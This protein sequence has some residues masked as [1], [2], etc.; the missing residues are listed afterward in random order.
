MPSGANTFIPLMG[1]KM[2]PY[3][4]YLPTAGAVSLEAVLGMLS[5]GGL[6]T[7]YNPALIAKNMMVSE[8][9]RR[10][11]SGAPSPA[12]I[13]TTAQL[14]TG[15]Q[16]AVGG[17]M[18]PEDLAA[19]A[20][21]LKGG[22][23][24]TNL[25]YSMPGQI[26]FQL[27]KNVP[28]LGTVLSEILPGLTMRMA[29]APYAMQM[30]EFGRMPMAQVGARVMAMADQ[31]S[32]AYAAQPRQFGNL[33]ADQ[34]GQL[35]SEAMQ[36]SMISTT[37]AGRVMPALARA[38]STLNMGFGP[39]LGMSEALSTLQAFTGG[40]AMPG[41][42]MQNLA[43][44][45]ASTS[46]QT[47]RTVQDL[48][49][50]GEQW[51]A[52]AGQSGVSPAMGAVTGLA[53]YSEIDATIKGS[54]A[55]GGRFGRMDAAQAQRI[56]GPK[57]QAAWRSPHMMRAVG[58]LKGVRMAAAQAGI[59]TRDA[60]G[61]LRDINLVAAE[62]GADASRITG[63][64]TGD[65]SG[66]YEAISAPGGIGMGGLMSS[67]RK[68]GLSSTSAGMMLT[69]VTDDDEE[70]TTTG[71]AGKITGMQR[72]ER[73]NWITRMFGRR[74][75]RDPAIARAALSAMI[76]APDTT[77]MEQL[78]GQI[79]SIS[80]ADRRQVGTV[81]AMLSALYPKKFGISLRDEQLWNNQRAYG[82]TRKEQANTVIDTAV[83][84]GA[85]GSVVADI[86]RDLV[87]ATESPDGTFGSAVARATGLDAPAKIAAAADKAM[88]TVVQKAAAY[89]VSTVE[90][91]GGWKFAP[92]KDIPKEQTG[93]LTSYGIEMRSV[94]TV[95]TNTGNKTASARTVNS[96]LN[97]APAEGYKII[98][99]AGDTEW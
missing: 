88:S 34:L 62:L 71:M 37:N 29:A 40:A 47:G 1:S 69:Q 10:A 19:L 33:S 92:G 38:V 84:S 31:I 3:G 96:V 87:T 41:A 82:Q 48:Q 99:G 63:M 83:A 4:H 64:I 98:S 7:S 18:K 51:G 55:L 91:K 85:G 79:S 61:N 58:Y 32:S 65:P 67:L 13:Q 22:T 72:T 14:V 89:G 43:R 77:S 54:A 28:I 27:A 53:L 9:Y 52:A 20:E 50:Y 68:L 56:F 81:H 66:G 49:V 73:L 97:T 70:M 5:Q 44:Q 57:A 80:G 2:T 42:Y 93:V 39:Q 78:Y 60:N 75:S 21:R 76:S 16:Q 24:L 30:P 26:G 35:M 6:I 17:V 15:L 36:R 59:S 94:D 25:A 90:P 12:D 11:M 86:T 8:M 23:A 74:L 46:W 45:V 95:D